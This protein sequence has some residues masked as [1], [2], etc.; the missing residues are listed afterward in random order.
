LEDEFY[1][2]VKLKNGEE[3]FSL[4]CPSN[5]NDRDLLILH[6][7]ITISPVKTRNGIEYLVQ[8]W[9]KI[10]NEGM[11]V[12]FKEDILTMSELYETQLIDMHKRYSCSKEEIRV[13]NGLVSNVKNQLE[14][15]YRNS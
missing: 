9:I 5:E 2:V 12:I 8:P 6:Y 7:P 13:Y 1:A 11:F 4:V 14:R 15:I 10:G 3:F